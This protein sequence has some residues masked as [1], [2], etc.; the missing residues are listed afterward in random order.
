MFVDRIEIHAR[1]GNGGNGSA[2]FRREKYVPKG[3]P[4]GGDGGRGGDVVLVVDPQVDHLREFFFQSRLI[5]KHGGP[6]MGRQKSGRS[7]KPVRARVPP[8][9]LVYRVPVEGESGPRV[10]EMEAPEETGEEWVIFEDLEAEAEGEVEEEGAGPVAG[11]MELVADLTGEGDEF[12]LCRGGRGGKGNVHFKSPVNQ[13][14]REFTPGGEGEEGRFI[15]ELRKIADGGLVG[16]PNAGKSTLLSKLSSAHPKVAAYPFTTLQPVIGVLDFPGFSRGTIADIPGLIEGA[17][18]N[19]GL[20]HDFLRHIMRCSLLVF[21]LDMAGSEGRHPAEDFMTLRKEISL[22]S[23]ELAA[24]PF[25]VIANKMD[26]PEAEDNL[27]AFRQKFSKYEVLA[28]SAETGDGL[29]ALRARLQELIGH[30]PG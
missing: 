24:R 1:A 30:Q 18:R 15:F 17:H 20:G 14:P 8:G 7:G 19:V 4:D 5:A 16:Y 3:G 21:V 12:V 28:I 27:A 29:D 13:A 6:G 10:D 9:T 23:D 22:Y 26:L 25:V 2:S 11:P